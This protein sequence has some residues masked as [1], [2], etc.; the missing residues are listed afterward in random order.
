MERVTQLEGISRLWDMDA[1]KTGGNIFTVETIKKVFP[2]QQ[3]Y[4][5]RRVKVFC[6]LET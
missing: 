1:C 6:P 4:E 3:I 5:E 2:R